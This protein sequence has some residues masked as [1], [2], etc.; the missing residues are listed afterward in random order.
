[1]ASGK[2]Q[3][4]TQRTNRAARPLP[5]PRSFVAPRFQPVIVTRRLVLRAP[6]RRDFD[7]IVAGIGD[8]AVA[9]NLARVPHPYGA[10]DAED[11]LAFARWHAATQ[12]SLIL[13]I[14]RGDGLIGVA[15]IDGIPTRF[16]LGY[17]LARAHWGRGYGREAVAALV[18]YAFDV[19][20]APLVRAGVFLDNP[21][22][23]HLVAKLGFR[24]VGRRN[25]LSRARGERVD[26][27]ATVLPRRRFAA[28][29]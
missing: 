10:A 26:F 28:F 1:M 22:S 16:R 25:G 12:R 21:A 7:A 19:I 23:L 20:G 4:E 24:P 14:T 6:A 9:R 27:L 2:A 3:P 5:V 8:L 11:F 18:A 29:R 17:W 13:A 15:S